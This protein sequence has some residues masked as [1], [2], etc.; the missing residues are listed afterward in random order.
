MLKYKPAENWYV[1]ASLVFPPAKRTP[2]DKVLRLAVG[3]GWLEACQFAK[4][5]QPVFQGL[6][7]DISC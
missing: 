3:L 1:Y 6:H 7:V 5:L 2:P 4:N